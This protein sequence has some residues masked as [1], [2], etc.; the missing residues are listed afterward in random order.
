[1][2]RHH[3]TRCTTLL[4]PACLT[5]EAEGRESRGQWLLARQPRSAHAS[6]RCWTRRLGPRLCISGDL[7]L[8]G[9]SWLR[10]V[11]ASCAR[12]RARAGGTWLRTCCCLGAA[13]HTRGADTAPL[14][15]LQ[16]MADAKKPPELI[17]GNMTGG[18][19]CQASARSTA[20][21]SLTPCHTRLQSCVYTVPSSCALPGLFSRGTICCLRATRPTRPCRCVGRRLR[22][23]KDAAGVPS[24]RLTRALFASDV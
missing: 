17:S 6:R 8:T 24:S 7:W 16:G 1:M 15:R 19:P 9:G 20:L 5:Q 22:A 14:L 23:R 18:A 3:L 12:R 2:C 21:H 10:C 4:A 11:V 13:T